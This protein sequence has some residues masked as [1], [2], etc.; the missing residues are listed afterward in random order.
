MTLV[1]QA[2]ASPE[3]L[4]SPGSSDSI[5]SIQLN[6]LGDFEVREWINRVPVEDASA[7]FMRLK[8]VEE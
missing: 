4:D 3:L 6:D 5:I 8:L 2:A 1:A 7:G